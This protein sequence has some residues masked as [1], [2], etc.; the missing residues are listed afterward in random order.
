LPNDR[1][2]PEATESQILIANKIISQIEELKK[3]GMHALPESPE[4]VVKHMPR[5]LNKK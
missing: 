5:G 1:D 2:V 3:S 4:S